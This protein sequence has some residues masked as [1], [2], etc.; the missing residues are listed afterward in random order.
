ME[1][2]VAHEEKLALL[3]WVKGCVRAFKKGAGDASN[4]CT[5]SL[6]EGQGE[7]KTRIIG[8]QEWTFNPN[9]ITREHCTAERCRRSRKN[10][11]GARE[12]PFGLGRSLFRPTTRKTCCAQRYPG[13]VEYGLLDRRDAG[14][15]NR[16]GAKKLL[17]GAHRNLKIST[18]VQKEAGAQALAT[19]GSLACRKIRP[20]P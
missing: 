17:H 12:P 5:K 18:I 10:Q 9:K 13:L 8:S 14:G 19:S 15:G 4:T 3:F 7:N 6:Q 11:E 1:L 2:G 20:S 16:S